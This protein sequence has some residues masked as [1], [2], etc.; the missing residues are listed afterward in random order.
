MNVFAV[1]F[2]YVIIFMSKLK[3]QFSF[4]LGVIYLAVFRLL[5][6]SQMPDFCSDT[7]ECF[8]NKITTLVGLFEK[9]SDYYSYIT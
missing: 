1:F 4:G 6:V 2:T 5:S 7:C 9:K 3:I 8:S